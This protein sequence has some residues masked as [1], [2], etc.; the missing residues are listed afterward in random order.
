MIK[1][2]WERITGIAALR[3]RVAF[4]ETE[5]KA[6]HVSMMQ[7]QDRAQMRREALCDIAAMETPKSNGTVRRMA[8]RAREVVTLAD[9][10]QHAYSRRGH[11]Y[12][13]VVEAT[14]GGG[15]AT[16]FVDADG[17]IHPVTTTGP[18]TVASGMGGAGE[19]SK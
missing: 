16:C 10:I 5:N 11:D 1:I 4:L 6:L 14:G 19:V 3:N 18:F 12:D 9:R 8:K 7:A 13:Y 15:G 17:R 2:W